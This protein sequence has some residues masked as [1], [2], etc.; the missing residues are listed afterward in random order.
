MGPQQILFRR[1][2]GNSSGQSSVIAWQGCLLQLIVAAQVLMAE[3]AEKI[4]TCMLLRSL[5]VLLLSVQAQL[6]MGGQSSWGAGLQAATKEITA[7]SLKL[8]D[9]SVSTQFLSLVPTPGRRM[10]AQ[11]SFMMQLNIQAATNSTG[12]IL[13]NLARLAVH[14]Q[15]AL[16]R[17]CCKPAHSSPVD[18]QCLMAS[19]HKSRLSFAQVPRSPSCQSA[20][21]RQPVSCCPGCPA[22]ARI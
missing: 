17:C 2:P 12:N 11:T 19:W 15:P 1:R 21:H 6:L 3:L 10:Q 13:S 7:M 18:M 20:E 16:V 5:K 22:G 8:P 14:Y 9:S 4:P